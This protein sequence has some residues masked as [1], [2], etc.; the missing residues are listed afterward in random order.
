MDIC[1]DK[2]GNEGFGKAKAH[3]NLRKA[4]PVELYFFPAMSHNFCTNLYLDLEKSTVSRKQ[5]L[6]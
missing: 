2:R 5:H 3:Q 4:T 1:K 6:A